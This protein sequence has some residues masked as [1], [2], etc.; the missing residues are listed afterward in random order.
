MPLPLSRRLAGFTLLELLTVITIIA[1]LAGLSFPAYQM[2]TNKARRAAATTT[3]NALAQACESFALEYNRYPQGA[4]T[5]TTDSA[6]NTAN[7]Q[8]EFAAVP[9]S[10]N[11]R[12]MSELTGI[13]TD[14]GTR[15]INFKGLRFLESKDAT[16]DISGDYKDGF[17]LNSS[18][19]QVELFDP[20]GFPYIVAVDGDFD[21]AINKTVFPLTE[22]QSRIDSGALQKGVGAVALGDEKGPEADPRKL[23]NAIVSWQ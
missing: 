13:G 11:A 10:Y 7:T 14:D 9:G 8:S 20:F 19:N 12:F 5:T 6:Y 1:V 15:Y 23:R 18:G 22:I 3:V 16:G 21:K 2:V 4:T 17:V